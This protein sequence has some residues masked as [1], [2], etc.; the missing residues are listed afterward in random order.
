MTQRVNKALS[1]D[2]RVL[3]LTLSNLNRSLGGELAEYLP[4]DLKKDDG[5]IKY[6]T[7]DNAKDLLRENAKFFQILGYDADLLVGQTSQGIKGNIVD[8]LIES[9]IVDENDR[10]KLMKKTQGELFKA[11]NDLRNR[12]GHKVFLYQYVPQGKYEFDE[13]FDA[14]VEDIEFIDDV[15]KEL[16]I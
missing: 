12:F 8:M 13:L 2:L 9:G 16:G 14:D 1:R 7:Y 10:E 3:N 11:Y 4:N 6:I 15:T 5:T